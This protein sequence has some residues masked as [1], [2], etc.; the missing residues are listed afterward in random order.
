MGR[1]M[2]LKR[3]ITPFAPPLPSEHSPGAVTAMGRRRKA[4]DQETR[5]RVP[6]TTQRL[7]PVI[8]SHIAP[9]RM[10]SHAF[11]PADQSGA[12]PARD[13]SGSKF[14]EVKHLCFC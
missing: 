13:D 4:D 3:D 7:G 8:P 14:I 10:L 5:L 1:M 9:R 6:E 2:V 11:A 12:P